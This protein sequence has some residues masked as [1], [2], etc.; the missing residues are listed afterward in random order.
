M[1]RGIHGFNLRTAGAE[2]RGVDRVPAS[3]ELDVD[4]SGESLGGGK[5]EAEELGIG[6]D[7]LANDCSSANDHF[8]GG[9]G[10]SNVPAED[11]STVRLQR[12]R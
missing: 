6:A 3:V 8:R 2:S 10:A 1:V 11:E 7:R 9:E 4:R 12:H 5:T